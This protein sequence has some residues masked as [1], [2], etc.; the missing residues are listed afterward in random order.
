MES[1]KWNVTVCSVH[2]VIYW[3]LTVQTLHMHSGLT[4]AAQQ[5]SCDR[6]GQMLHFLMQLT[7]LTRR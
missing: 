4:S 7:F 1:G 3:N 6:C 2:Y 5:L